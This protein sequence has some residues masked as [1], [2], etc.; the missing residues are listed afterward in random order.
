[1]AC[2]PLSKQYHC[3]ELMRAKTEF[4]LKKGKVLYSTQLE[5]NIHY[6]RYSANMTQFYIYIYICMLLIATNS[7]QSHTCTNINLLCTCITSTKTSWVTVRPPNHHWV[8]ERN[9]GRQ[10]MSRQVSLST[11]C[12]YFKTN[13]YGYMGCFVTLNIS[14]NFN[15]K[16]SCWVEV[17]RNELGFLRIDPQQQGLCQGVLK[18]YYIHPWPLLVSWVTCCLYYYLFIL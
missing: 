12:C 3:V 15:L 10:Q 13:I 18:C 17:A 2:M 7:K 16:M 5:Q 4:L 1:M 11:Y 14:L 9:Q 6:A 8:R